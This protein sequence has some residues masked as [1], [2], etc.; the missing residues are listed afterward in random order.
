MLKL[1]LSAAC[2]LMLAGCADALFLKIG[3]PVGAGVGGVAYWLSNQPWAAKICYWIGDEAA[4]T[5]MQ[6]A[7]ANVDADT[8]AVCAEG[9]AYIQTAQDIPAAT[10]N[11]TL[12]ASLANLP[13]AQVAQIQEAAA[14]LDEFLP[15]AT[16]TLPLTSAQLNDIE[17]FLNGWQDGTKTCLNNIPVAVIQ[18][19][20][21]KAK[22]KVAD[23]RAKH[24][25]KI[26]AVKGGW[27]VPPAP[28]R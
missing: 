9:I 11:A 4:L 10:V 26:K 24:P 7:P 13:A 23:L 3:I 6:S 19:A 16:S 5:V 8:I 27:F 22:G 25:A 21:E 17:G 15:A 14:I 28:A 20:L 1:L 2:L 18:A 12:A